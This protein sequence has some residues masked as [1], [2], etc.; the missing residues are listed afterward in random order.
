[1]DALEPFATAQM[2]HGTVSRLK[3]RS[4]GEEIVY[5]EVYFDRG[6]SPRVACTIFTVFGLTEAE[7]RGYTPVPAFFFRLHMRNVCFFG[8]TFACSPKEAKPDVNI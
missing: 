7:G 2:P 4:E 1:V 8:T 6:R 5:E 3:K